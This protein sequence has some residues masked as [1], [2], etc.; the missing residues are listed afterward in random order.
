[1]IET[2]IIGLVPLH[3][4]LICIILL[5]PLCSGVLLICLTHSV[6]LLTWLMKNG[7]LQMT[8]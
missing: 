7:G 8:F 4:N 3:T 6:R 1:M 2:D 5:L